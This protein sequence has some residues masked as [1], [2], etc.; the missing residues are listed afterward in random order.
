M[1]VQTNVRY[2]GATKSCLQNKTKMMAFRKD[3]ND[4][5]IHDERNRFLAPNFDV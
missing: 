4:F 5:M 1:Y 2:D 3:E